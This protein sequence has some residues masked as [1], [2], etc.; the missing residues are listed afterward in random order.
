MGRVRY[1]RED[2]LDIGVQQ[3]L[4]LLFVVEPELEQ[5]CKVCKSLFI[6]RHDEILHGCVNHLAIV[7]DLAQAGARQQ[8]ALRT[9]VRLAM[10]QVIGIK[11]VIVCRVIRLV[12]I[13]VRQ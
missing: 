6:Y 2:V 5:K 9:R 7:E 10:R 11:Q 12:F 13:C 3:L 8:S 4:V 1:I